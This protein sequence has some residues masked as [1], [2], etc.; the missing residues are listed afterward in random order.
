MFITHDLEEAIGLSDRVAVLSAGPASRVV[1]QH[2]V[3]LPRP[4]H[5]LDIKT[6]P[7]FGE[8]YRTIW[9]DLRQEVLKSYE[10]NTD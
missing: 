2:E 9:S 6:E 8:L 4:R 10:R 5:L 7:R 3:D 1:A